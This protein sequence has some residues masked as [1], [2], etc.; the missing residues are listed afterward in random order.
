MEKRYQVRDISD[1][2][3]EYYQWVV[4]DTKSGMIMTKPFINKA[5]AKT[6]AEYFN[7]KQNERRRPQ[8]PNRYQYTRMIP[9]RRGYHGIIRKPTRF[10]VGEG[11]RAERVNITP[12]K[13]RK[14]GKRG[15]IHQNGIKFPNINVKVK[16]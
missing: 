14:H 1:D 4:V 9:A 3:D 5:T 11:G 10:L 16:I 13:N 7:A 8:K 15:L 2:D 6:W 12:I